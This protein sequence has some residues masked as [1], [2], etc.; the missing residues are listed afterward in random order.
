MRA[1]II[2]LLVVAVGVALPVAMTWA[3]FAVHGG[4][5]P[6]VFNNFILNARWKAHSSRN[7]LTVLATS[8]PILALG[9]V[10][11]AVA[12]HNFRRAAA[13]QYGDVVLLCTLGGLIAGLVVVPAA[14]RQY[15][16]MP[17]AIACVFAARGLSFL[18]ELAQERA[19]AWVLVAATV[20]LLIL[21]AVELARSLGRV[22]GRQL[23]RLRYVFEHTGP[24]DT[25]LD[26]WLGTG[27]FRPHPLYYFFMH[28]ELR[29]MLTDQEKDTYLDA[30]E[31][32]RVRPSLITV[33]QEL[34]ALGPRFL[35]FL[36]SN[37]VSS[38]GRFYF[39]T[40]R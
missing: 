30:L 3:W 25:V 28:G 15:H 6:F 38:D 34:L 31:S 2:A 1:R 10:G 17:L 13:R 33:D 35:R 39:P 32:G 20:P 14:Y 16:L 40:A 5:A 4:A 22:D 24:A 36:N 8:W 11:A 37:Y 27:V 12:I 9:V 26:G 29:V 23:A 18:V 21:P 19:R 7:V